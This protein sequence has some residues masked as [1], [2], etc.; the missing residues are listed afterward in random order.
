M[1]NKGGRGLLAWTP[2]VIHVVKYTN[3]QFAYLRE[4]NIES[5]AHMSQLSIPLPAN[6]TSSAAQSL[7]SKSKLN[8]PRHKGLKSVK[9]DSS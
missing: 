1:N 4:V 6:C 3:Q 7:S 8:K 9:M 5:E 2:S